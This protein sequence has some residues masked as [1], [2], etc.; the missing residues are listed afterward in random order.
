MQLAPNHHGGHSSNGPKKAEPSG[1]ATDVR[2]PRAD[3]QACQINS[4]PYSFS[5]C[6]GNYEAQ[7]V[8][9]SINASI[10]YQP[11]LFW[12]DSPNRQRPDEGGEKKKKKEGKSREGGKEVDQT[13]E[14][15]TSPSYW[16]VGCS[17]LS[18]P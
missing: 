9:F 13:R 17:V 2:L 18:S 1:N 4:Q 8:V 12:Q 11:F 16:G 6:N 5:R 14:E 3:H 7:V 15:K 10:H